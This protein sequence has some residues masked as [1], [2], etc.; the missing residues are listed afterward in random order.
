M[1]FIYRLSNINSTLP[2]ALF[3]KNLAYKFSQAFLENTFIV[4][5][6]TLGKQGFNLSFG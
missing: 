3:K 2:D 4:A 6:V 5:A 1:K